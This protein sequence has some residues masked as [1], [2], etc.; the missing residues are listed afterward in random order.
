VGFVLLTGEIGSGKT[1][2]IQ[3]VL[4]KL[5][6]DTQTAVVFNTNVTAEQ[7]L[8][9]IL[10]QFEL[11]R[12]KND[13]TAVLE[14]FY[15]FLIQKYAEKKRVLL[16]IDEAQNLSLE[17]LEEVRMLSNLQAESQAL[18]QI[19]LVGQPELTAKLQAPNLVQFSQRIAVNFH[20]EGLN[21]EESGK[22]ITFRLKTAGRRNNLFTPEAMEL[23][24]QIS[25]GIPRSINLLCN[26]ALVYGF[27]E[28]AK[29][30]GKEIITQ[31]KEDKIGVGLRL[32]AAE[33]APEI[34]GTVGVETSNDLLQTR[35]GKLE[36]EVQ[37][38]KAMVQLYL[39]QLE[40]WS[41][42]STDKLVK[43]LNTLLKEE[44]ERNE[45]LVRQNTL[46]TVLDMKCKAMKAVE[47]G[48]IDGE[49]AERIEGEKLRGLEGGEG[50][51]GGRK[52]EDGSQRPEDEGRRKRE[53]GRKR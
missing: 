24:Y 13:K 52:S 39:K 2:L 40:E 28:S 7:L 32:D 18:L 45:K 15:R 8:N 19:M 42:E 4:G 37:D 17:A 22:Y 26:A 21:R 41:G 50:Q 12:P 33:C 30:I 6:K 31:I 11:K 48:E 36:N 9:F 53:D 23:I 3:Y 16:I 5:G 10:S 47:A 49:K 43:R 51:E 14:T 46:L 25:G 29:T 20:L 1:T 27:A 35:V 34:E 38:L 44:R